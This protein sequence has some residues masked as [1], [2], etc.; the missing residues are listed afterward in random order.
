MVVDFAFDGEVVA[1]GA[2]D[3]PAD[4]AHGFH[5][6]DGVYVRSRGRDW[7]VTRLGGAPRRRIGARRWPWW[8]AASEEDERQHDGGDNEEEDADAEQFEAS[9]DAPSDQ[10]AQRGK[11]GEDEGGVVVPTAEVGV[12]AE[13]VGEG[14]GGSRRLWG[15]GDRPW[16]DDR[17]RRAI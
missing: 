11:G 15:G 2:D 7:T 3:V 10:R 12:G 8:C 6:A 16:T 17:L 14:V 4:V 13:D 9:E 5:A 1:V